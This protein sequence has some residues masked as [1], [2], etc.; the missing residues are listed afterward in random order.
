MAWVVA[1]YRASRAQRAARRY[2]SGTRMKSPDVLNAPPPAPRPPPS[3]PRPN[4]ACWCGSGD[5]YKRC[6]KEADYLF[7]RDEQKRLDANKV[8]P[9]T[10]S[11]PRDVPLDIPRPEYAVR[12]TSSPGTGL[13]LR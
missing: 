5:K 4:E 13:L 2:V 9:G 3:L 10:V 7:L 12:R 8:R 11:P 1:P 6:H